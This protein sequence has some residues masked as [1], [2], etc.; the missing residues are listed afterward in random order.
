MNNGDMFVICPSCGD[1]YMI[2][3]KGTVTQPNYIKCPKCQYRVDIDDKFMKATVDTTPQQYAEKTKAPDKMKTHLSGALRSDS[4]GKGRFDLLSPFALRRVALVCERGAEIYG[5]RNWEKGV[6]YH[7]FIDSALRHVSQYMMGM[8]D[9]DHVAQAVWNL[10]CILHFD[11]T[12]PEL[13][14]LPSY[15]SQPCKSEHEKT[16]EKVSDR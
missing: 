4:S 10:M 8:R 14:D 6:P 3:Y 7:R 13:F 11:A 16:S 1:A 15:V 12:Q 2:L 5:D 9:E